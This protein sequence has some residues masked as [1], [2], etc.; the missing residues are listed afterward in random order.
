MTLSHRY[1]AIFSMQ[2]VV[3]R[4]GLQGKWLWA[5]QV[6]VTMTFPR[7]TQRLRQWDATQQD[8]ALEMDFL[9]F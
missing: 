3:S 1:A 4:N 8:A 6:F 2:N 7:H 9:P 5:T